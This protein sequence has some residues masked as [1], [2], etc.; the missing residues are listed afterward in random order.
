MA[1]TQCDVIVVGGGPSGSAA[2]MQLADAGLS[3]VLLDKARFPRDKLCGG[4]ISERSA[5]LI[6]RIFGNA[7]VPPYEYVSTGARFFF[8]GEPVTRSSDICVHSFLYY[9]LNIAPFSS[10]F[11]PRRLG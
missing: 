10:H 2:A 8:D 5:K 11:R 6:D 1:S 9:A 3:V 4:L 7:V